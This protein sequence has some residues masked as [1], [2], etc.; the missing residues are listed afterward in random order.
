MYQNYSVKMYLNLK[1]A[2]VHIV[3]VCQP[4]FRPQKG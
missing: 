2:K 3:K 4:Y 1:P